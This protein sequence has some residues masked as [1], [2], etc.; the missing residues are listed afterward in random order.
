MKV[1]TPEDTR[2]AATEERYRLVARQQIARYERE[3]NQSAMDNITALV[4]WMSSRRPELLPKTWRQYKA[5]VAFYL[6][7]TG[8]HVEASRLRQIMSDGCKSRSDNPSRQ[9][10]TLKKKHVTDHE[11]EVVTKHLL[12]RKTSAWARP[13]LAFF[14]AGMIVGLRPSEWASAK[15]FIDGSE[16]TFPA[17]PVLRVLN[18]KA[19]NGRAHGTY[20]HLMLDTLEKE[21]L[22][23]V[24]AA[25]TYAN[26]NSPQ[27]LKMPKGKAADFEEYYE[28]LRKEFKRTID[29]LFPT[30]TSRITL[31]SSR[32]QFSANV[33]SAKYSLAEI[34]AL[35]GHG[36]DDTASA[37]Y[38]RKRFGRNRSGLPRPLQVEVQRI[39]AVYEGRPSPV[40]PSRKP[41]PS[42]E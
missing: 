6:E 22:L 38:G 17:Y 3:S 35:M 4:D 37:H 19:T 26:P 5:S 29:R 33:K 25:I 34:A 18:G 10:S 8:H 41:S 15:L 24:R 39:K 40:E 32:H 12:A 16:D 42:M 27:G 7:E 28:G 36:S 13:C 14:K 11:E 9:T 23:W 30:K 2:T 21:D 1:T 20:R 31:Y